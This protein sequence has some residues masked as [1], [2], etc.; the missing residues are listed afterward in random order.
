M[1]MLGALRDDIFVRVWRLGTTLRFQTPA[2]WWEDALAGVSAG[3]T[4]EIAF[5]LGDHSPC[6]TVE[7]RTRC[8]SSSFS[9]GGWSFLAPDGGQSKVVTFA[10]LLWAFL[11]G[12]PFGMLSLSSRGKIL[13]TAGLGVGVAALSWTLPYWVT[14][15]WGILLMFGGMT[16]ASLMEPWIRK[17]LEA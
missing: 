10:G 15:W 6:L 3:D 11:L 4:I 12:A 16:T 2:W 9:L 7:G 14:P 1:F 13:L 8:L 5:G 17:T